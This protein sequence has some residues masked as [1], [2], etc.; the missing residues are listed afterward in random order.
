MRA[1]VSLAVLKAGA[2]AVTERNASGKLR[3][4]LLREQ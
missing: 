3:R 2:L 1:A 4:Y